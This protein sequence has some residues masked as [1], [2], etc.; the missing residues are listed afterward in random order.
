MSSTNLS[1]AKRKRS[2]A[3][4]HWRLPH[5]RRMG[6]VGVPAALVVRAAGVAA[7]VAPAAALVVPVR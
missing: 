7:A 5:S 1:V 2:A 3:R 4:R 6:A